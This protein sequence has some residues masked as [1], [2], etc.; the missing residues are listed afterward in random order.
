MPRYQ[1]ERRTKTLN[2]TLEK[3]RELTERYKELRASRDAIEELVE[4]MEEIEGELPSGY[5]GSHHADME[6]EAVKD[7][8]EK[9]MQSVDDALEQLH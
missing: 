1:S 5:T 9:E 6:W 2:M 7:A 4:K 8:I 3:L